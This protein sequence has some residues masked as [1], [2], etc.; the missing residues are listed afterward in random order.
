MTAPVNFAAG[1]A[2]P[3]D[4]AGESRSSLPKFRAIGRVDRDRFWMPTK[5]GSCRDLMTVKTCS[6]VLTGGRVGQPLC[7]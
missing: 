1:M 3:G 6:V 7:Y 5:M 2:T 4:R